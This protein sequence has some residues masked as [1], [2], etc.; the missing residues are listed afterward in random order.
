MF[1]FLSICVKRFAIRFARSIEHLP[2]KKKI[3]ATKRISTLVSDLPK[4]GFVAL[5]RTT[6][7][8]IINALRKPM[9]KDIIDFG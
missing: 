5:A 8:Q 6:I 7:A 4:W 2:R 3:R 1:L 9:H